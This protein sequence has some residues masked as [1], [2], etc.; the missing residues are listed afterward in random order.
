MDVKIGSWLQ[1]LAGKPISN[2][3][4]TLGKIKTV[5]KKQWHH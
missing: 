3:S 1:M 4:C 5:S 2:P